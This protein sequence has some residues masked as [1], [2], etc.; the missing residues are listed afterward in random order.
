MVSFSKFSN[1]PFL[2]KHRSVL[3][4]ERM[5]TIYLVYFLN[6]VSETKNIE[7]TIKF[8]IISNPN[9]MSM[10]VCFT[11]SWLTSLYNSTLV[12]V[13]KVSVFRHFSFCLF[14]SNCHTSMYP[15]LCTPSRMSCISCTHIY[16]AL[17]NAHIKET[18]INLQIYTLTNH[19][20]A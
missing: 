11:F 14:I 12:T 6:Y 18:K 2:S 9:R 15:L 3:I 8:L 10:F 5:Q 7:V 4:K 20:N 1:R 16:I 17:T 13:H 19:S